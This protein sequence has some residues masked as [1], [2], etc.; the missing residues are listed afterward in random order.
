M[1][2]FIRCTTNIYRLKSK[3]IDEWFDFNFFIDE[4][5]LFNEL[6]RNNYQINQML[7]IRLFV[8]F[9]N[10]NLYYVK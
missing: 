6:V 10:Y 3:N 8:D 7:L 9:L 4:M 2:G 1:L 5:H